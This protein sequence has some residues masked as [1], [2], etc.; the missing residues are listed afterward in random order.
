MLNLLSL[1][2]LEA[3]SQGFRGRLAA[4]RLLRTCCTGGRCLRC[5]RFGPDVSDGRGST[6]GPSNPRNGPCKPGRN[7]FRRPAER[8]QELRVPNTPPADTKTASCHGTSPPRKK[9]RSRNR[10]ES[11]ELYSFGGEEEGRGEVELVV[12]VDWEDRCLGLFGAG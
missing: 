11:D 5:T 6:C 7:G 12:V 1:E 9:G 3:L 2:P 4:E 10:A 8:V